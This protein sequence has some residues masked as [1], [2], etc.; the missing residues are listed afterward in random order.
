M[1]S[2]IQKRSERIKTLQITI[3]IKYSLCVF[4]LMSLPLWI[5]AMFAQPKPETW[6]RAEVVCSEVRE[7]E[8]RKYSYGVIEAETGESYL[9]EN[10]IITYEQLNEAVES[11]DKCSIVYA[12]SAEGILI[13]K[14]VSVEDSSIID[15]EFA[16]EKW[17]QSR[18]TGYMTIAGIIVAALIALLLID[19]IWCKSDKQ[20]IKQLKAEIAKRESKKAERKA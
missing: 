15:E 12:S 18:K 5:S 8:G 4:L 13:G 20:E 10:S 17:A 11:G 2:Y 19:R 9:F 1:D 16:V 7:E 6:Q 14:A 3:V